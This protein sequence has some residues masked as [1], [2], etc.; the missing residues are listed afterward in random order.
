MIIEVKSG[1]GYSLFSI[2]KYLNMV[3]VVE[4]EPCGDYKSRFAFAD[5][6]CN[7]VDFE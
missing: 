1:I 6:R 7:V 4:I 5:G 3:S 2:T